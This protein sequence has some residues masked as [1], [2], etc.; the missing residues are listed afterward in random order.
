[1]NKHLDPKSIE[2]FRVTTGPLPASRKLYS[3]APG[4]SDVRVPYREIALHP[5]AKEEP[6]RVY[7]TSGPYSDPTVTIDVHEGLP[8]IRLPWINARGDSS[9]YTAR[10]VKPED[11]GHVTGDKLVTE[12]PNLLAVGGVVGGQSRPRPHAAAIRPRRR[13]HRRDGVCGPSR[14]HLPR[15]DG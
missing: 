10:H 4:F 5:S 9:P 14:K 7:D 15:R 1:M 13:H 3:P 2:P 8:K 11:N 6:V 12:F